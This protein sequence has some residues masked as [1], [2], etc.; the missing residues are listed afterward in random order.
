EKSLVTD[1]V[2]RVDPNGKRTIF[3]LTK[4]DLAEQ[5]LSDPTRIK[6]ILDGKLFPMKALGYFGVVTGK[7]VKNES[8]DSIK[9]YEEQFFK[10]S[11]LI[12]HDLLNIA[13]CTTQNLSLAVSDCFWKMVKASVTQ[14]A[15]SF[16]ALRFNLETEWRSR[17]SQFREM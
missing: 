11:K 16:K 8:I 10:H 9:E 3:V 2:S 17:Y 5:N 6:K 15:D 14:Q 7:G 1:L 12:K 4:M 13:Q